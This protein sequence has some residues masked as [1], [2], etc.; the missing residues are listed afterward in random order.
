M[1][2]NLKWLEQLPRNCEGH[3]LD[4]LEAHVFS[5]QNLPVRAIPNTYI[6]LA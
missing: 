4:K 6:Q 1:V 5:S 3:L 2:L